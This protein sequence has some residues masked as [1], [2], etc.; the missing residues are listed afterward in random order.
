[1]LGQVANKEDIRATLRAIHHKSPVVD[2]VVDVLMSDG[3]SFFPT[4]C[5]ADGT[6]GH[7]VEV[8]RLAATELRIAEASLGGTLVS[9]DD[10]DGRCQATTLYLWA[11]LNKLRGRAREMVKDLELLRN[12][13]GSESSQYTQANMLRMKMSDSLASLMQVQAVA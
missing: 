7:F 6:P 9:R 1:M 12:L 4:A 8:A 11:R 3:N 2:F 5:L 10:P 13:Q